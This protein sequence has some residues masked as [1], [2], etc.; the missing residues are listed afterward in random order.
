MIQQMKVMISST[1]LDLP[2]HREEAMTACLRQGMFPL[3][4]ENLPASDADAI[5]KSRDL[6]DEA[7]IYLG[8]FAQRYGHV[9]VGHE[10]SITEMEYEHATKRKIERLIFFTDK[11]HP[12]KES[13]FET[14]VGRERLKALKERIGAAHVVNFFVSP[15]DLRSQIINSLSQHRK[16]P[17]H[18]ESVAGTLSD[19][20]VPPEPYIAHPYILLQ[21][22]TLIGRKKELDQLT[23]WVTMPDSSMYRARIL[24]IFALGGMGKSALTWKWFNDVAPQ[25]MKPLAGRMWWSFQESDDFEN[26]ITSTLAYVTGQMR[27]EVQKYT[28]PERERQLLINLDRH[29]FLLVL[30]GLERLLI[31]Y[32]RLGDEPDE[33]RDCVIEAPS[34]S[35]SM[36]SIREQNRLRKTSD[37]RVGH[38]LRKLAGVKASRILISTRLY[39]ADL[40]T[41]LGTPLPG[42]DGRPLSGLSDED[43]IEM[44]R[45]FRVTGSTE[46]LLKMFDAFDNHPLLIQA[47]AGIVARY[48]KHPRDFDLW[49]KDNPDFDPF[50]PEFKQPHSQIFDLALRGI[51]ENER[52]VLNFIA[53]L[54]GPCPYNTLIALLVND[55]LY[56]DEGKLDE[57]L[58][59]LED[60]GLLGW[61]KEVTNRYGMHAVVRGVIL[62]GLDETR[63][64]QIYEALD[65]Y[66]QPI[67]KIKMDEVKSIEDLYLTV[68]HYN[69]LINLKRYD[70][71]IQLFYD[72]LAKVTLFK[73]SASRLRAELLELLFPRGIS[74]LPEVSDTGDQAYILNAL[75]AT[76]L[77]SQPGLAAELYRR[78]F[79]IRKA[80]GDEKDACTA[81]TN[82]SN[83]L[84]QSGKLYEAEVI[85]RQ[86]LKLAREINHR[87]LEA[88]NLGWLGMSLAVR[89]RSEDGERVIR[90]SLQIF[91]ERR[92]AL[93]GDKHDTP[94][95]ATAYAFLAR[96]KL[97]MDD[98]SAARPLSI[99]SLKL[100][101]VKKFKRYVVLSTRMRGAVALALDDQLQADNDLNDALRDARADNIVVEEI[102]AL[103]GLAQLRLRQGNAQ[104]AREM[105]ADIWESA[106]E[107]PY[108]LFH[109]EACN[110]LAQ[111]EREEGNRE[112]ALEAATKAFRL[113]WCDGPPFIYHHELK[114]ARAHLAG[115]GAPEPQEP[116]FDESKYE[117][118]PEIEID[119]ANELGGSRRMIL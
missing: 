56:P 64:K 42:S 92:E 118:M 36:T 72:H 50:G 71:A 13:D 65:A 25:K 10:I 86:A 102:L 31:S 61:D 14:G 45:T 41:S 27:E 80:R 12:L 39:P 114:T 37:P 81:L 99:E 83:A 98:P 57:A 17:V 60:R 89:G 19:I 22:P 15:V 90:Q 46:S 76:Y 116:P 11:D 75:A 117:Q 110:V 103:I 58:T 88:T 93:P 113:A 44:W 59:E 91:K 66:F 84:R 115:L 67:P 112:R 85:A 73:L 21:T 30:N 100:A 47:L 82:L 94:A 33:Q 55:K 54:H 74:E 48:R 107:G 28:L 96:L 29:P 5:A 108:P 20:P 106:E 35:G 6:V 8:I 68:E 16:C 79:A 104:A 97:W 77:S 119:L 62:S 43:A 9:P 95:E 40:E 38:F 26:F 7:D 78:N 111:I 63:K 101:A 32:P 69:A 18:C 24:S 4:M 34:Q 2:E 109:A 105:L 1:T 70:D 3:C 49:L 87:F 23:E 51:C 53:A 52:Q